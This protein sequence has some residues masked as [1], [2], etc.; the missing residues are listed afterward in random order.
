MQDADDE[1]LCIEL[2]ISDVGAAGDRL[3]MASA[4][5]EEAFA[6][7]GGTAIVCQLFKTLRRRRRTTSR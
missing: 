1:A 7:D 3:R 5:V 4:H 2:D 6:S